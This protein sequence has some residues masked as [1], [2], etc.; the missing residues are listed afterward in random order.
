MKLGLLDLLA[1]PICKN[2]PIKL[3]IFNWEIKDEKFENALKGLDDIKILKDMTKIYRGKNKIEQCVNLKNDTIQDDLVRYKLKFSE[4]IK[5]FNEILKNLNYIEILTTGPSV[6]V[7]EK[8]KEIF[9]EFLS[10]EKVNDNTILIDFINNQINNIFLVNWYFQRAEIE[11]GIMICDKCKRW[12]PIS[13][14]IPQMLPDNLRVEKN[15]LLFLKKWKEKIP[16]EVMSEGI[17]FNLK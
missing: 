1:C 15:E 17:P 14:S 7:N 9:N 12:Y 3:Q 8:V 10:M 2:W 6:T 11:D 16:Q 5:K 4:Y 13:E